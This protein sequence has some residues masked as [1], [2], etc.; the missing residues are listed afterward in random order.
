[1]SYDTPTQAHN[2]ITRLRSTEPAQPMQPGSFE[3]WRTSAGL[4]IVHIGRAG[5]S[6][7]RALTQIW[8]PANGGKSHA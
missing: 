8:P 5:V 3:C 2:S 6:G 7:E 1:M 4:S